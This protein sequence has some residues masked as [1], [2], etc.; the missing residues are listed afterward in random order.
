M[1]A[2]AA[3]D[4]SAEYLERACAFAAEFAAAPEIE[5]QRE[6]PKPVVPAIL[7]RR[8]FRMLLPSRS[9]SR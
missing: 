7:E 5:R 6:L 2:T 4:P 1:Q 9:T 8:F 3:G